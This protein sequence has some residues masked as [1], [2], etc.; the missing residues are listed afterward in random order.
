M[1]L[2]LEEIDFSTCDDATLQSFR[3]SAKANMECAKEISQALSQNYDYERYTLNSEQALSDLHQL[4][5]YLLLI[6]PCTTAAAVKTFVK[7]S[8]FTI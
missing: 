6:H 3:E 4:S 2:F 7:F 5:F 1:P 8:G